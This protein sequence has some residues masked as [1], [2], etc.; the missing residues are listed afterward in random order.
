MRSSAAFG[1][2]VVLIVSGIALP[3][4]LLL[5]ITTVRSIVTRVRPLLARM[6]S[7]MDHEAADLRTSLEHLAEGD[8]TYS[9][10][11]RHGAHRR[12][13]ATTS[14]ARSPTPSTGSATAWPHRSTPTT[15]PAPS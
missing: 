3:L 14:S 12:T 11:A 8:L 15:R 6:Q 9:V 2:K 7:L 13:R 10:S 4:L 5:V 1:T